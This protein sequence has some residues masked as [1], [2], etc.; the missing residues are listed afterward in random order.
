MGFVAFQ[1]F[2]KQIVSL[3][4]TG[5]HLY[6]EFAVKFMRTYLFMVVVNCVQLLSSNFFAAIGKPIRGL[7]L[8]LTRQVF[9]LVPLLL[10]LPRI[11]GLDGLLFAAPVADFIAFV[12][13]ALT[14]RAEL[15]RLSAAKDPQPA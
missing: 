3:F 7:L 8:A 14:M 15:R 10:I 5:D 4:G 1:L 6:F 2:P 9:F 12:T 13:S 11:W